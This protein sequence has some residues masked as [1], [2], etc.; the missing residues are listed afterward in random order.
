MHL[1]YFEPAGEHSVDQYKGSSWEVE[2]YILAAICHNY[3]RLT[4]NAVYTPV[5]FVD[6]KNAGE[7]KNGE[8]KYYPEL[9]TST[10]RYVLPDKALRIYQNEK[11][12]KRLC[13][14]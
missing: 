11:C 12:V 4:E 8:W 5:G 14:V 13:E 2:S 9:K 6:S 3:L 1:E 10:T 7:V